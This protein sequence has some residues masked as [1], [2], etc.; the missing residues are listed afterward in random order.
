M[1]MDIKQTSPRTGIETPLAEDAEFFKYIFKKTEKIVCAVFFILRSNAEIDMKDS[2]L[3]ATEVAANGLL[4]IAHN[5]LRTSNL[6][7]EKR[8]DDF[9]F[10]LLA[11]ES[12]L[13][14][15]HAAHHLRSDLLEVFVHEI[16][17]VQRSLK[18]YRQ[19]EVVN[20]LLAVDTPT[21]VPQQKREARPRELQPHAVK[22]TS[23]SISG[24]LLPGRRD[25]ILVILKDK[26]EATIKDI[27]EQVTDCSEKTIQREL[28]DLIK[29]G[30]I[31]RHG[32][33][34]WS[35]YSVV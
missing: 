35:K 2:I 7:K 22:P 1:I 3:I 24:T 5:G 31:V 14:V 19:G 11:L 13:R 33:R 20:P 23:N 25:R 16:E 32:E 6:Y 30:L 27:S 29:D 10:G 17:S 15:L 18:K 34:R 4:D 28:I 8:M 26:G 9:A 12:R 21:Y